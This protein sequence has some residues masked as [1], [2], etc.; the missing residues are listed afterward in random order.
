MTSVS[1]DVHERVLTGWGLTAPSRAS[2]VEP[3]SREAV[4]SALAG[5]GP[6]GVLAR[7]LGRSYGDAA[8]NA[9]GRVLS[10]TGMDAVRDLDAERA[11]V[12]V[13]AGISIEALT[14]L[15][16]PLGL[17]V[18]VSP[19]T[20][21]VTVGGA[22][23]ADVHGKNHHVDGSFCDHVE[24]FDLVTPAGETVAVEPGDELFDAT[25]GGMGLT[26]VVVSARLRL[27]R[28]GSPHVIVDRE[29]ARDLDDLM[30][31]MSAHDE[32]YRYS[33]AW[34]DCLARGASLGRSVLMRG[35]H[36]DAGSAE[37][38]GALPHG[39]RVSA[40]QWTPP[41]LLRRSTVRA[42]NE[43]YYRAAPR[44]ERGRVEHLRSFFYPL[45]AVG[46]WNRI[47]GPSGFVQYQL[48]VPPG[49]EEALRQSLERLSAAGCPSFLAVLKRFGP[50][51]TGMISFPIEGWTLAFDIPAAL[52]GLGE[53]LDGL[54]ELVVEAGGRVY[55][56]KDSRLRPDV[57]AAMYPRLG[58]WRAARERIDPGGAMRS[59]LARRLELA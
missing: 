42:F 59:D 55:L 36:A 12:T 49:R 31:R 33:V 26:G 15:L 5:A 32:E 17:F 38:N 41:G 28:V 45:D 10:M 43:V 13:D 27:L 58:E 22:I 6:R 16:L 3:P 46:G 30:S 53:L 21:H 8:Q 1:G 23:A 19:G 56:A 35:D 2:V 37:G 48:A 39:V 54:D 7:G 29:R 34:I 50:Q 25:A 14:R 52:P 44:H 57:L 4:A 40:P 24:S 20:W 9:G 47:Y 11:V 51:R 18:H